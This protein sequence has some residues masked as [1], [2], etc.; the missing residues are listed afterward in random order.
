MFQSTWEAR[1]KLD[2]MRCIRVIQRHLLG[3]SS[4]EYSAQVFASTP[5]VETLTQ[6]PAAGYGTHLQTLR[7][8]LFRLVCAGLKLENVG[9]ELESAS[10][11]QLRTYRRLPR[12]ASRHKSKEHCAGT[13]CTKTPAA[14]LNPPPL[15]PPRLV[16]PDNMTAHPPAAGGRCWSPKRRVAPASDR[17]SSSSN[18][19]RGIIRAGSGAVFT[20]TRPAALLTALLVGFGPVGCRSF[21]VAAPPPAAGSAG[22]LAPGLESGAAGGRSL[23]P[24]APAA[25]RR[26]TVVCR[27]GA[28]GGRGQDDGVLPECRG[29]AGGWGSNRAARRRSCSLQVR[30]SVGP[31]WV[32]SFVRCRGFCWV[33]VCRRGCLTRVRFCFSGLRV[34][35]TQGACVEQA[36]RN[37]A[38][39][40]MLLDRFAFPGVEAYCLH[41]QIESAHI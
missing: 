5:T 34:S 1:L 28:G 27:L 33:C 20:A 40:Y 10:F 31:S 41:M 8:T 32:C 14:W 11:R 26:R 16:K 2:L 15:P 25:A 23:S 24:L 21:F 37:W 12:A 6:L 7:R 35:L 9:F 4:S 19:R 29:E 3:P 36:W 39:F 30:H 13:E 22:F 17:S 18:R 38:L